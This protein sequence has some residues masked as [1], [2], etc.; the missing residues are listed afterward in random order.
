V[1][2]TFS[3]AAREDRVIVS[4][5]MLMSPLD[6][7][8]LK[9]RNRVVFGAHATLFSEGNQRFGEPGTQLR[10]VG[11]RQRPKRHRRGR[12]MNRR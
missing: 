5:E 2:R 3:T 6:V 4:Y 9:L 7:G 8:P 10:E 1:M 12:S 11:P